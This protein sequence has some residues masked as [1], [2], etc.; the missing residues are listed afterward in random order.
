MSSVQA[1]GHSKNTGTLDHTGEM[2]KFLEDTVYQVLV[3]NMNIHLHATTWRAKIQ[4]RA[5]QGFKRVSSG[6]MGA[7]PR[8]TGKK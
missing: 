1:Y 8:D 6:V 4:A 3:D 2:G 7:H 5:G